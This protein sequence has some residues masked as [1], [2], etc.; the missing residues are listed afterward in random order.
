MN[1]LSRFF[2]EL[3]NPHCEHCTKEALTI[4]ENNQIEKEIRLGLE[5]EAKRCR[6]CESYERQLAIANE[7][8]I[9]LTEKIIN[10]NA[11]ERV[12]IEE[13]KQPKALHRGHVPFS[14]IRNHLETESRAAAATAKLAAKPDSE[15]LKVTEV[16]TEVIDNSVNELEDAVLNARIERNTETGVKQA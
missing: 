15:I 10:P 11:N 1:K 16:K 8:I 7:Q 6:S 9:K 3:L 13:L 12:I 2:H 5:Q 4:Y 14:L